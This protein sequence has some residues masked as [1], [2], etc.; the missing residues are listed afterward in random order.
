A[1]P[2]VS[3]GLSNDGLLVLSARL[4]NGGAG[5]YRE[6]APGEFVDVAS[7]GAT[8]PDDAGVPMD[9]MTYADVG[10]LVTA[11][12]GSMMYTARIEG[13]GVDSAVFGLGVWGVG[14]D[15]GFEPEPRLL[16]KIGDPVPGAKDAEIFE[17]RVADLLLPDSS[18]SAISGLRYNEPIETGFNVSAFG[19]Q[20]QG[21]SGSSQTIRPGTCADGLVLVGDG[22]TQV[23]TL[24][25]LDPTC[26]PG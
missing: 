12:D 19:L 1:T 14:P 24:K 26:V 11:P 17:I 25:E 8:P 23:L 4:R 13:P 3:F 9:G 6:I 20:A 18:G 5:I 21:T 16:A 10:S 7:I 2:S 22:T 15:E